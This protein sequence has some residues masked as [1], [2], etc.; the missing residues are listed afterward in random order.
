MDLKLFYC[1]WL[2]DL[3][4]I[5]ARQFLDKMHS[6]LQLGHITIF[7]GVCNIYYLPENRLAKSKDAKNLTSEPTNNLF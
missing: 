6:L 2:E 7:S 4:G 5:A 3:I 1:P